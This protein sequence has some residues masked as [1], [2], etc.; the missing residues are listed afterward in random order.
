MTLATHDP[1][2]RELPENDRYAAWEDSFDDDKL[3]AIADAVGAHAVA[4]YINLEATMRGELRRAIA[5][6]T[7][8]EF[9]RAIWRTKHIANIGKEHGLCEQWE[10]RR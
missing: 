4:G 8:R 10:G 3:A 6:T 7:R 5:D 9:A 1:L 2:E